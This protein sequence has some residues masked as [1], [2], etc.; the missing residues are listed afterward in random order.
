M[1][2]KLSKW[3]KFEGDS[4]DVRKTRIILRRAEEKDAVSGERDSTHAQPECGEIR[5]RSPGIAAAY[6]FF[7]CRCCARSSLGEKAVCYR[8]C[9]QPAVPGRLH[10]REQTARRELGPDRSKRAKGA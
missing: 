5:P 8:W 7:Q 1:E 3:A 10:H 6:Q 2:K 4:V 9:K